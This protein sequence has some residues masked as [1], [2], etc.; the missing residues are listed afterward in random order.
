[1]LPK[2][3]QVYLLRHGET[4]WNREDRLQ[5]QLDSPLTRRGVL[6]ALAMGETLR[7][8]LDA[9]CDCEFLA[10]P[11]GRC[12]Q[13]AALVAEGT[14]LDF[15]RADFHDDLKEICFGE[16]EGYLLQDCK[17][18]NPQEWANRRENLW[19]HQPPRGE[20]FAACHARM[21]AWAR[22]QSP[23]DPRPLVVVAHGGVNRVLRGL[24]L[25][26][27]PQEILALE[28]PQT[29]FFGL[30]DGQERRIETGV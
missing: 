16:W 21:M 18:A 22:R 8:F 25:G 10:S 14:G 29:A 6:Q 15:N 26:L 17:T 27:G 28:V 23:E 7:T 13:T 2:S 11:L 12:R 3:R 30:H 4:F 1:M 24:Y 9:P 5:G 20:S 19:Q